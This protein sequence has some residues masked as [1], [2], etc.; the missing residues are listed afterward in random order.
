MCGALTSLEALSL[1]FVVQVPHIPPYC[2]AM[3][4]SAPER[5]YGAVLLRSSSDEQQ[6][7][8]VYSSGKPLPSVTCTY[9][10]TDRTAACR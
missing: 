3:D 4:L 1:L 5:R 2:E 7:A 9:M 8:F 6:Q 10:E